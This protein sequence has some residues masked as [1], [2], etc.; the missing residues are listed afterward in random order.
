MKK[1]LTIYLLFA[2]IIFGS[3]AMARDTIRI[4]TGEWAP[5]ISESLQGY[6]VISQ[7]VA[8]A[9]RLEN[10]K[11]EY[12]F[13]PW[14]RA[15]AIAELG[16]WD[17]TSVWYYHVDREKLFIMS[18]PVFAM[19]EVFFHLKDVNFQWDNW[20]DLQGLTIG[21]TIAYTVTKILEDKQD[22]GGFQLEI[23]P[24]DEN[25]FKKLLMGRID[26]FPLTKTVAFA[27]LKEKFSSKEVRRITFHP[28]AVN[29]G[30]LYMLFSKKDPERHD[31]RFR[32]NRG[33]KKLKASGRYEQLM[34]SVSPLSE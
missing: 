34:K 27:L 9:F 8:E 30:E 3:R 17:A 26:L 7:I 28:K 25:N 18:D 13:F 6:G 2:V 14:G 12:G 16:K 15:M 31:M 4:S 1:L 33:L 5:Y 22:E 10:I 32:F 29:F 20:S 11:V 19:E 24:T 21:G 23:V